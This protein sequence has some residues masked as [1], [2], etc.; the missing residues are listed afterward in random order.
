[1]DLMALKEVE[2]EGGL[3]IGLILLRKGNG[4]GIL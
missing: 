2:W 4:G 3:W 1:M